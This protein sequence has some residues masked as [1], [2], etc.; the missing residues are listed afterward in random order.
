MRRFYI[1]GLILLVAV[2]C[3]VNWS[4]SAQTSTYSYTGSVQTYTVGANVYSLG[5]DARG[6]QGGT[7]ISFAGPGGSGG[8]VQ[9]NLAVTPG[10]VLY[11][12]VGQKGP[13]GNDVTVPPGGSN[14][15]GGANGGAGSAADGGGAGGGSSDIR[16]T[17]GNDLAALNSRL[18]VGG[19]GG[20][21]A[22]DCNFEVGGAGGDL[23]GG[24]GTDCGVY[25]S[26]NEGTPGTPSTGGLAA[27]TGAATAGGFGF[28]GDADPTYFGGGGG[29]GWYG[30]GG[31]Y[32]GGGSG[33]SSYTDPVLASVVTHTQGF[34]SGDGQV[35][36]TVNCP[37][38]GTITGASNVCIAATITLTNPT[39]DP[40]GV[41]T[42]SGP[43]TASV[44]SS[45]GMVTGILAG[46]T[47]ISYTVS[48]SCGSASATAPVTVNALPSVTII[49]AG[50][51]TICPGSSVTLGTDLFSGGTTAYLNSPA[52]S[53]PTTR[54]DCPPGYVAVGYTGRTGSWMDQ[55]SLECRQLHNGIVSGPVVTTTSNGTSFGGG[56]NGPYLLTGNNVLVGADLLQSFSSYFDGMTGY[57]Q[58]ASYIAALGDNTVSPISLGTI[59]GTGG[60]SDIGTVFVPNGN[61]ITGMYTYNNFYSSGVAFNYT[62]ISAFNSLVWSTTDTTQTINADTAGNYTVTVTDN[63][64]CS[65]TS[66]PLTVNFKT[67]PVI[68]IP[69]ADTTL[70]DG[71]NETL[72][73][74][75]SGET[76]SYQWQEDYGVGF[77]DISGATDSTFTFA[78]TY[79]MNGFHYRCIVTGVC[80]LATISDPATLTVNPLPGPVTGAL[81]V[82][83]GLTTALGDSAT[84]GTWASGDMSLA[85]V[86][87]VSGIVTGVNVGTPNITYTLTTGCLTITSVTVNPSPATIT[88][89]INV[90]VGFTTALNDGVAGGT[91]SSG[92]G[93]L[94]TVDTV[95]GIVSGVAAGTPFISYTLPAGC[96]VTVV[97]TVNALPSAFI[98]TGGGNYCAGAAGSDVSLSGSE[99]DINYQLYKDGSPVGGPMAGIGSPLDF[100][101]QTSTG[102]YTIVGTNSTT[103]CT[104][105]MTG[106]AI[107]G[108][109]PLPLP[110]TVFGGGSFCLGGAGFNIGISGSDTGISY[111][112]YHG[113]SP[114]GSAVS[115]TGA[116]LHF[117]Y[118]TAAGT[119]KVIA[120]NTTTSCMNTMPDSTII[121]VYSLPIVYDVTGGGDYCSGGSGRH[122]GLT[123]S[124]IGIA[125]QL[126]NGSGLVGGSVAGIGSAI[127]FGLLTAATTYKVAALNVVTGCRDTMAD[128]A[129]VTMDPLPA[130]FPVTG[131]GG[132]CISGSGIPVGLGGSVS[133]IS[134]QLYNGTVAI[135][136]GLSGTG[137]ALDFGLQT[138]AGT[139]TVVATDTATGC[140]SN[141]TGS[142]MVVINPLPPVHLLTSSSTITY[143]SGDTGIHIGV[144]ASEVGIAYTLYNSGSSAGDTVFGTGRPVKFGLLTVGGTYTVIAVDTATG[145]QSTMSGSSVITVKPQ[146][147]PVVNI[148][149]ASLQHLDVGSLDT[150]VAVITNAGINPTFQWY[151]NT[152][153]VSGATNDTFSYII[154]YDND[155]ISCSVTSGGECGGHTTSKAIFIRLHDV[156][157]NIASG[158]KGNIVLVPNPNKGTFTVKGSM[159][160]NLDEEVTLEITN[161]LGQ[162][163]YTSSVMTQNGTINERIQLG[164]NPA[165]GMYMLTIRSATQKDVFRFVIDQ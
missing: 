112:L 33:G 91:W 78:T 118:Q 6:A 81:Q 154:Y 4:A 158:N 110:Y 111:Q 20:G 52:A 85:T 43:A 106:N 141:M 77:S 75:A 64:G 72:M 155:S 133:G 53:G 21:G 57:A 101:P 86:N 88:G 70:C 148:L 16:T 146:V 147:I 22:D 39:G 37:T 126:Y 8:R 12:Y 113:A 103:G 95:S 44:D 159:G 34:Q 89:T 117:G 49:P 76:L 162:V 17:A 54:C 99:S 30:A 41:W 60:G 67:A 152:N 51:T 153:P 145:C 128:D 23:T 100:G 149:K 105:N 79:A 129:T 13:D 165:N 45:S 144:S 157:V 71:A 136:P 96:F 90:C 5:I 56:S 93:S 131:G 42:S 139:Y 164:N 28:G 40:G 92:D 82:C 38:A 116:L 11:V 24:T 83:T 132:Y 104:N 74:S 3:T 134:Y 50:P 122:I 32:S 48:N 29:G 61:V 160:T 25:N 10:Q 9:C 1:S 73:V 18:V 150:L 115:G 124:N 151:I 36:I 161:L 65:G 109:N 7:Y 120:T 55:F 142:R 2:L 87:A 119:Y 107:I 46:V 68:N 138:G 80:S 26:G 163:M 130:P 127:D 102:T 84:G 63:N 15:G 137:S 27:T 19:G 123:G 114:V 97:V 31:A 14:S 135:G 156:G 121:V 94:A 140:T 143:C 58:D 47:T 108:I 59:A 69:P 125:Y 66:A 35:I 98:V 62:A